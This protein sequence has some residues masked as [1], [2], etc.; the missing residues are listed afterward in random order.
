MVLADPGDDPTVA[1]EAAVLASVLFEEP[2]PGLDRPVRLADLGMAIDADGV[3]RLLDDGNAARLVGRL[4]RLRA[5]PNTEPGSGI[6]VV[7]HAAL[8]QETDPLA[9]ALRVSSARSGDTVTVRVETCARSAPKAD[10]V[11]LEAVTV[12][13]TAGDGTWTVAEPPRHL[14]T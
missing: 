6:T 12:T 14:A 10:L 3:I 1:L 8:D 9:A 11:P 13:F 4:S 5:T 7:S 2:L